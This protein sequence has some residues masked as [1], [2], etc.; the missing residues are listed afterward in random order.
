MNHISQKILIDANPI[1]P[2]LVT[3]KQTGI[4]RTCLEL[5][6]G[7]DSVRESLPFKIELFTQNLKG[8]SAKRLN[9]NFKSHHIYL[10]NILSHNQLS[11]KLRLREIISGYDL[12][13][14]THNYEIVSDPSKC[15]VTAHDAFFMKFDDSNFNYKALREIYPPFLRACRHI[16]TCSEYSK[17]DIVET[18][19]IDPDK[20]TVIPW[21]IDHNNFYI[22]DKEEAKRYINNKF[23]ISRPYFLSVSCDTGRK[24]TPV[25]IDSYLALDNPKHDLVLVWGNAPQEIQK[26][27]EGNNKIHILS[28]V[29]DQ[30]LRYLYNASTAAFNPSKYEGFGLP[31]LEAMACGTITITCRNS[32]IPEVGGDTAIYL[33]EPID[34]SIIEI[35]KLFDNNCIIDLN[36]RRLEGAK[37]AAKFSW[38][39]T[40]IRT[41][42]VYQSL[43]EQCK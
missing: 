36:Y 4:G 34:K 40:I 11:A 19:E 32:S 14:I 20:I 21:G 2:Y 3:G 16:I 8:V 30:D 10:R 31:V 9:T 7:L 33:E 26:K 28:G 43:F 17:N 38:N 18:M 24:R 15:I 5:I 13:H 1:V 41:C 25:L 12:Q 6:K 29:N 42:E 22:I 27:V 37:Q 39:K 23:N 35:M